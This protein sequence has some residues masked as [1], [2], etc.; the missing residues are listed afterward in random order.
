M[1]IHS[2][3]YETVFAMLRH[4]ALHHPSDRNYEALNR[5][6]MFHEARRSNSK[7]CLDDLDEALYLEYIP[8]VAVYRNL[9]DVMFLSSLLDQGP[10][11]KSWSA[12]MKAV[13]RFP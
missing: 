3:N 1:T 7:Q 12:A 2:V 4:N 9:D 6:M 8:V 13:T 10:I 5:L 11:D